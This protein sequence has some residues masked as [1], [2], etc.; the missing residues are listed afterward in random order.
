MTGWFSNLRRCIFQKYQNIYLLSNNINGMIDSKTISNITNELLNHNKYQAQVVTSDGKHYFNLVGEHIIVDLL[1]IWN[2][3]H[4]YR[5]NLTDK[6]IITPYFI[7]TYDTSKFIINRIACQSNMTNNDLLTL[8]GLE[9]KEEQLL[10]RQSISDTKIAQHPLVQ[11]FI[12]KEDVDNL[13]K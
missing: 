4:P 2:L 9:Y 7:G 10:Y 6:T 3:N 13:D 8:W 5:H 1:P 12:L 11:L